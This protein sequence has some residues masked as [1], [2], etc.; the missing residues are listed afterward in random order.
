MM[1][2]E[3]LP[4]DV[5]LLDENAR[6][7]FA[8]GGIAGARRSPDG[9]LA[10]IVREQPPLAEILD[11]LAGES[12]ATGRPSEATAWIEPGEQRP[13]SC[14]VSLIPVSG[15]GAVRFLVLLEDRSGA[16]RREMQL[17]VLRRT[18]D[19]LAGTFDLDR[20]LFSI[21]TGVTAGP[22]LGF[23]RALLFLVDE[24]S[25]TLRGRLAVGSTTRDEAERIW[26]EVSRKNL[27]L[28]DLLA[29]YDRGA[30]DSKLEQ[31]VQ[32][33]RLP[34]GGDDAL[35]VCWRERRPVVVADAKSDPRVSPRL[36]EIWESGGF[37]AVPLVGRDRVFGVVVADR[38]WM[39]RPITSE[40]VELLRLFGAQVGIA[41][42]STEAH[43]RAVRS[44]KLAAVGRI[45]AKLAHEI[46][47][48]LAIIG[49][50]AD[51]LR[52]EGPSSRNFDRNLEIVVGEV[53][54]LETLLR[55]VNVFT[56][57]A[58]P[59]FE[60]VDLNA[61]ATETLEQVSAVA[62]RDG[63]RVRFESD[64][65]A[66]VGEVRVDPAQMRQ[67]LLNLLANAIDAIAATDTEG[68]VRVVTRREETRVRV[69]VHDTGP[70]IP[71]EET[72]KIFEPF[73]STKP[74]GTGLGLPISAQILEDHDGSLV[75]RSEPGR[76]TRAVATLPSTPRS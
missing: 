18:V 38:Q 57:V 32:G 51:A 64:L 3:A 5:V 39:D 10:S 62:A 8:H 9:G 49:G 26:E 72:S 65:D 48:P 73:H 27:G 30:R 67:V 4:F 21:L 68:V 14:R 15:T 42:E 20:L 19:R 70:G 23:S 54:R 25:E 34:L 28:D 63:R 46:R 69:E 45:S 37:V 71:P 16:A 40:D 74:S 66:T 41:L 31:L 76:G 43:R 52:R 2:S 7:L 11:R 47:N 24:P 1:D 58:S 55:D 12:R 53:R 6:V 13:R 22:G 60:P 36:A 33:L 29:A 59:R 44:E 35:G 17:A 75:V 56:R 61:L 50:F